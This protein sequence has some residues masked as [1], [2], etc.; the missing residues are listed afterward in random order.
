MAGCIREKSYLDS[1]N[2]ETEI[3]KKQ[4]PDYS[5]H[6]IRVEVA[7]R[8]RPRY[9]VDRASEARDENPT[10]DIS[11]SVSFTLDGGHVFYPQYGEHGTYLDTLHQNQ[12][13][14]SK[15]YSESDY[16]TSR[17]A[18]EAFRNGA[19][20]VVLSYAREGETN[21]DLIVMKYDPVTKEGKTF[22]VNTSVNGQEHFYKEILDI[23][24]ERF[25]N[26]SVISPTR[27]S[28]ILTDAVVT[29]EQAVSVIHSV[30][31]ADTAYTSAQH[32]FND[33][34]TTFQ[35][36]AVHVAGD[37]HETWVDI[38]DF[39]KRKRNRGEEK[40]KQDFVQT[41]LI[42]N[43]TQFQSYEQKRLPPA[44][45]DIDNAITILSVPALL[46]LNEQVVTM[47]ALW[48]VNVLTRIPEESKDVTTPLKTS[49]LQEVL[50]EISGN[51]EYPIERDAVIPDREILNH[52]SSKLM[53][54]AISEK[55]LEETVHVLGSETMG[56]F[57]LYRHF[58]GEKK[59]GISEEQEI[60]QTA[61]RASQERF[62]ALTTPE[63]QKEYKKLER[64]AILFIALTMQTQKEN[65]PMEEK[66]KE[67]HNG[68]TQSEIK[69][70]EKEK[71][72]APVYRFIQALTF[73]LLFSQSA[74]FDRLFKTEENYESSR[75]Q[76]K[77]KTLLRQ[78]TET[79]W[80]LLS[81]I[82]Y[83]AMIREQGFSIQTNPMKKKTKKKKRKRVVQ[84]PH[85]AVLYTYEK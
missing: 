64:L 74:V 4:F 29:T 54:R 28:A 62:F 69:K 66:S 43:N 25:S 38:H 5:E 76:T 20:T 75:K 13:K 2:G 41:E 30:S 34:I 11:E 14:Y 18:E 84:L 51:H 83:L 45:E 82:Y 46:T 70:K 78:I 21:R 19:T 36:A 73:L 32:V 10:E 67:F 61:A 63:E 8:F 53:E 3:V 50:T 16:Q 37:I 35:Y 33:S 58:T 47:S 49:R 23:A 27:T 79:P 15:S 71:N 12:K 31:I 85:V 65:K 7:R 26:L 80:I 59:E 57:D 1:Y 9:A 44:K 55:P 24:K 60:Q 40:Q 22:I 48:A 77:E 52:I 39:F 68:S 56:L 72:G 42:Q 17:L 6:N 81:I